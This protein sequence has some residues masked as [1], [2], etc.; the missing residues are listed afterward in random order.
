M[1]WWRNDKNKKTKT[2]SRYLTAGRRVFT[3]LFVVFAFL[4]STLIQ[5]ANPMGGVVFADGVSGDDL[6]KAFEESLKDNGQKFWYNSGNTEHGQKSKPKYDLDE[7]ML[8]DKIKGLAPNLSDDQ[9]NKLVEDAKTVLEEYNKTPGATDA[10][11]VGKR[12]AADKKL[13][14]EKFGDNAAKQINDATGSNASGLQEQG[15][16][17]IECRR[18][19]SKDDEIKKC[20]EQFPDVAQCLSKEIANNNKLLSDE[21]ARNAAI[22]DCAKDPD[23]GSNGNSE[24]DECFQEAGAF[25]WVTCP[26]I[27]IIEKTINGMLKIVAN[28]LQWTMLTDGDSS[29]T[30]RE[31]WERFR[32][33]ANIAFVVVFL[34]ML[35]S[36]ATSSG[37]SN[38]TVKRILPTIIVTAVAVNVS[39][40]ICAIIVDASN[41]AGNAIM[42]L[43]VN[44]AG[45]EHGDIS[46]SGMTKTMTVLVVV[47]VGMFFGGTA[48]LAIVAV[49]IAF[50]FRKAALI[51]LVVVSPF[52]FA[53]RLLPNT[54]IVWKKWWDAFSK[55]IF[56]YPIFM[57]MWGASI[58]CRKIVNGGAFV[59]MSLIIAPVLGVIPLI[60]NFGGMMGAVTNKATKMGQKAKVDQVGNK[61]T[62]APIR[63][64]GRMMGRGVARGASGLANSS[65]GRSMPLV[66]RLGHAAAAK[67]GAPAMEMQKKAVENAEKSLVGMSDGEIMA[68]LTNADEAKKLDY[69]THMAM[70]KRT[71][72]KMNHQQATD[73]FQNA[74]DKADSLSGFNG[75]YFRATVGDALDG[76]NEFLNDQIDKMRGG[77]SQNWVPTFDADGRV[78]GRRRVGSVQETVDNKIVNMVKDFDDFDATKQASMEPKSMEYVNSR[79]EDLSNLSPHVNQLDAADAR[80]NWVDNAQRIDNDQSGL[81]V[82]IMNHDG[83]AIG[84]QS[85]AAKWQ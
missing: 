8:K 3:A 69:A 52:A 60:Q 1:K 80:R 7:Q 4:C 6:T 13:V 78:T 64:T 42:A 54:Q 66:A 79:L 20:D 61:I 40:Y 9:V 81:Y 38:Y 55:L 83:K 49:F 32:Q 72:D 84:H 71:K 62:S 59:D 51:V 28:Q 23:K 12:V 11:T 21:K 57:A 35:Y 76:K 46:I 26:G 34:F 16:K 15:E 41:I 39:F 63:G 5:A 10:T 74:W 19:T 47:V 82:N 77:D 36:M 45:K 37:L 67:A 56:I 65:L 22:S 58:W 75:Q 27:S 48:L 30:I 43:M 85:T 53:A 50:S 25:S 14:K 44:G 68:K 33:L 31:S 73:A 70:I 2:A 18:N 17:Y 24:T 29:N